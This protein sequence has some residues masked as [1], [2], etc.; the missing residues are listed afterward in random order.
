MSIEPAKILLALQFWEGDKVQAMKLLRF[1]ADLEPRHSPVADILLV[2]RYDCEPDPA[3]CDYAA[4][5]F[6]IHS[7]RSKRRG[8]GWPHGCNELWFATMEWA[9]SMLADKKCAPYKAI[10]TFEADGSP[11]FQDWLT[12]LSFAWDRAASKQKVYVAGP[13][14][15]PPIEHINGNAMFSTDPKFLSWV[16][17][18]VGGVPANVGWDYFLFPAFKRWGVGNLPEILSLYHTVGYTPEKFD[19]LCSRGVAWV[20]GVKDTSLM[21]CARERW[22]GKREPIYVVD[23]PKRFDD[24]LND[25]VSSAGAGVLRTA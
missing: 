4:R 15:P 21:E 24:R 14:I 19:E 13:Y 10:F 18:R 20:H 3:A 1:V 12:R 16:V 17:R 22:L 25:T 2:N 6:N 8:T 23:A 11:I 5:K 7:Y 9:A